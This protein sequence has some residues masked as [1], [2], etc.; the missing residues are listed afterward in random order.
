MANTHEVDRSLSRGSLHR[1]VSLFGWMLPQQL[2]RGPDESQL[3]IKTQRLDDDPVLDDASTLNTVLRHCADCDLATGLRNA[4]PRTA[5][6]AAHRDPGNHLVAAGVPEIGSDS[7]GRKGR[8]PCFDVLAQRPR[9]ARSCGDRLGCRSRL[10]RHAALIN[11]IVEGGEVAAIPYFSEEPFYDISGLRAHSG[12]GLT[13]IRRTIVNLI[14]RT[15]PPPCRRSAIQWASDS[16]CP[17]YL[18]DVCRSLPFPL[19]LARAR[20]LCARVCP[21]SPM[22]L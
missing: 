4:L 14:L 6:R 8:Q 12:G 21:S 19:T 7:D 18:A 16:R 13:R 9:A 15:V 11:D 20:W 10:M 17:I 2:L 3:L 1:V 5:V 22:R